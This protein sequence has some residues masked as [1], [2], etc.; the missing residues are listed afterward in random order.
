MHFNNLQHFQMSRYSKR[1]NARLTAIL[2]LLRC[3]SGF[4]FLSV[5]SGEIKELVENSSN[6]RKGFHDFLWKTFNSKFGAL[7][8]F[9]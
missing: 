8:I 1:V 4:L 6:K 7:M 5:F 9:T 3:F 2:Q